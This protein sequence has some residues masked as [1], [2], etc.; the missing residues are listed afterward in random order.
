MV[1]GE[2]HHP[3]LKI[4]FHDYYFNYFKCTIIYNKPTIYYFICFILSTINTIIILF[5]SINIILI[6]YQFNMN[7]YILIINNNIIIYSLL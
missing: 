2:Y 3:Y 1:N 4:I 6:V 7:H 5:S